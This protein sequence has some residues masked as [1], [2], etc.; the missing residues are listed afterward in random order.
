[1]RITI[2]GATGLLGKALLREWKADEVVG[3]GSKDIDIRDI[4]RV[5]RVVASTWPE[6]IINAAAYTDVDGCESNQEL[7][8]A[9]NW[10][11]AVNVAKVSKE[12][13]ARLLFI[14]TDY[15]FDGLSATPYETDHPRAP[16]SVYGRSKA[17]AEEEI[18]R[19]SPDA[20]I[21]R[22]SWLFGI[23]GKCFPDTILKLASSRSAIDVVDDQRGRPTHAPDLARAIVA[24]CHADAKGIVHAT[25][26]G[27]CTWFEFAREIVRSAGLNTEVRPTTSD[28]FVRPAE[29]PKYS[30][31]SPASLNRYGIVMPHWKDALRDY[32]SQRSANQPA[33][34]TSR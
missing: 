16:R 33:S 7:A 34:S 5:R 23:G 29:R 18:T 21:V 27:D 30:V 2:F 10:H 25:N 31:L 1:M 3:L 15:V 14:S 28:K 4:E 13:G 24:L 19:I 17:Q 6:W 9:V 32:M 8:F 26:S 20:C 22:T 11:G 12:S